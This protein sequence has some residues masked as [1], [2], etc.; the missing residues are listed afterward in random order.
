MVIEKALIAAANGPQL[1][2]TTIELNRAE[3]YA[4]LVFSTVDVRVPF[5]ILLTNL[6]NF[7]SLPATR[8]RSMQNA[9][10]GFLSKA[11]FRTCSAKVLKLGLGLAICGRC[12]KSKGHMCSTSP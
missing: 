5:M 6:A 12:L 1:L 9:I 4:K 10:F 2:R 11:T 8:K 7:T 3:N